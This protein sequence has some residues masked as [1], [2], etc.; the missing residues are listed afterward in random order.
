MNFFNGIVGE[1]DRIDFTAGG[2]ARAI[3]MLGVSHIAGSA[4]LA[5]AARSPGLMRAF[6]EQVRYSGEELIGLGLVSTIDTL[7]AN[8]DLRGA[9]Q[10]LEQNAQMLFAMRIVNGTRSVLGKS[11]MGADDYSRLQRQNQSAM[12]RLERRHQDRK[13][14]LRRD[15]HQ[16][17]LGLEAR[18]ASGAHGQ[19]PKTLVRDGTEIGNDQ[20]RHASYAVDLTALRQAQQRFAMGNRS[21]TFADDCRLVVRAMLDPSAKVFRNRKLPG[22]GNTVRILR[23]ENEGARVVWKPSAGE[24]QKMDKLHTNLEPGLQGNREVA[25]YVIDRVMGHYA[26]VMPTVYRTIEGQSGVMLPFVQADH[27]LSPKPDVLRRL[28]IFDMV[29]GNLDRHSD[30]ILRSGNTIIPIDHGLAFP[31]RNSGQGVMRAMFRTSD[32]LTKSD[33]AALANLVAE[34]SLVT[35]ALLRL[36]VAQDS[37]NAMYERVAS[38]QVSGHWSASWTG[39]DKTVWENP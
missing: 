27:A 17:G 39:G 16:L 29:I 32:P 19:Q 15:L 35:A 31:L 34:R 25:A 28:A 12:Q 18:A 6:G 4:H 10:A 20:S 8:G 24:N 14:S 22:G 21:P 36:G 11:L 1:N 38:L 3:A 33:K 2:Y 13:A 26:G 37:I 5:R 23:F 30:N 9:A 7:V